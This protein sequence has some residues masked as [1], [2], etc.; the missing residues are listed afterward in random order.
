M[1][2]KA[3]I[4]CA[5]GRRALAVGDMLTAQSEYVMALALEPKCY[6]ARVNLSSVFLNIGRNAAAIASARHAIALAPQSF[7][8][9]HN[10]GY[11]LGSAGQFAECEEAL[12]RS[13]ALQPSAVAWHSMGLCLYSLGRFDASVAAFDEVLKLKPGDVDAID[14]RAISLLGVGRYV[15]GLID[16]KVR[17]QVLAA[18]PLM[19]SA[20]PEWAGEDLTGKTIM[21]LHE[22]GF[23]DT[24]QF[25]RFVPWLKTRCKAKRVILSMPSGII[26]L[27]RHGRLAD[28][29][30]GI[31]DVPANGLESVDYK[32]PML[33]VPAHLGLTIATIPDQP[34]LK[35]P[36]R[37]T[38]VRDDG[39]FRVGLVWAGKP[40]YAQDRWRSMPAEALFELISAHPDVTFVSLQADE[41]GADLARTGLN[42]FVTDLGPTIRDW[43]DT[44]AIVNDLDLLVSVDTA[45]AHLAGAMGKPVA[46]MIPEASCWRW[47]DH[48][49]TTTPWYRDMTLHRQTRQ[50]D[51]SPV[52]ASVNAQIRA[53]KAA[54]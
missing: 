2:H 25:V 34:Y 5:S 52:L 41:R 50:G 1:V 47:L 40:M 13:L 53:M 42:A 19:H 37:K 24:L 49:S 46:L 14:K 35:A 51:W 23:G 29:V 21:V 43:C 48:A 30:I 27:L 4:H 26:D 16:N 22:Q 9:W 17:W 3:D 6:E 8:G 36:R 32:C 38:A 20:V 28:E 45:P 33:T 44:A 31:R 18:H 15:E 7:E 11:C 12:Q 10:L 39:R 54:D